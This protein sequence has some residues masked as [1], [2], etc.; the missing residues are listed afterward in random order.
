MGNTVLS[1]KY[2]IDPEVV[3][4]KIMFSN[5]IAI[6]TGE[7]EM[8]HKGIRWPILRYVWDGP[9][10]KGKVQGHTQIP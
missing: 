8:I 7:V 2:L 9:G 1:K 5:K 10:V 6:E 4:L 3:I